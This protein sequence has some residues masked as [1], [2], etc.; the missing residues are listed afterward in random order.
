MASPQPA[1]A[2]AAGKRATPSQLLYVSDA[3]TGYVDVFEL[4]TGKLVQVITGLGQPYGECVDAS[5][6]VYVADIRQSVVG[7]YA[8]GGKYPIKVLNDNG[9]N[10]VDCSVDPTTGNL[11]VTNSNSAQ[12]GAGDVAIFVK[13]RRVPGH[14][15]DRSIAA[16]E[17]CSYDGKGNF[18]W[19]G[20]S[21]PMETLHSPS[22]RPARR[23]LSE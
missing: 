16:Y 2:F 15:R 22:S 9:Y 6:N 13:A 10:P 8:H 12:D 21:K 18:S 3:T 23:P 4:P 1:R 20:G 19:M 7:E 11:A 17:Y 5:G 14:F